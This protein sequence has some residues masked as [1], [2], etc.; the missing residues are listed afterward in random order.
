MRYIVAFVF[1][2]MSFC[3]SAQKVDSLMLDYLKDAEFATSVIVLKNDSIVFN[4]SYGYENIELKKKASENTLYHIENVAEQFASVAILYLAQ[5]G[6]LKLETS[7]GELFKGLDSKYDSI[8]VLQLISNTSGIKSAVTGLFDKDYAKLNNTSLKSLLATCE[9]KNGGTFYPDPVNMAVLRYVIEEVSGKK[10]NKFLKKNFFKKVGV[11]AV[12]A[13][14]K[15]NKAIKNC[16]GYTAT[17][18]GLKKV[19]MLN[20]SFLMGHNGVFMTAKEYAKWELALNTGLILNEEYKKYLSHTRRTSG[21]KATSDFAGWRIDSN[22]WR[23][24]YYKAGIGVGAT[25]YVKKQYNDKFELILLSNG[26]ALFGLRK[27]GFQILKNYSNY[28]YYETM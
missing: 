26:T 15:K 3:L 4:K 1:V 5:Q 6:K 24:F 9:F 8:T 11:N 19:D 18:N 13:G 22:N 28:V 17:E 2:L 14:E 16:F 20:N 25:S 27:L 12:F 10:Y 23:D 21:V 7:L